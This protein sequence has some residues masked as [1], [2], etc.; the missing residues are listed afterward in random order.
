MTEQELQARIE[1]ARAE[2]RTAALAQQAEFEAKLSAARAEERQRVLAETERKNKIAAF[3]QTVTAGKHA[4]P[5]TAEDLVALLDEIPDSARENVQAL[6]GNIAASGTVDLS[7][8]G[9]A[10]GAQQKTLDAAIANA[11]RAHLAAGGKLETF[12]AANQLGDPQ[13]YDLAALG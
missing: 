8:I 5:V 12:F 2:E 10:N 6:L 3:A 1:A 13:T 4:L 7:E 9:T 11:L